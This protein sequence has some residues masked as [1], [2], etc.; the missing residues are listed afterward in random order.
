M[1]VCVYSQ[2]QSLVIDIGLIFM[3]TFLMA[4]SAYVRIPLF[5][6]PV[7]LTLQ[8]LVLF[9]SI[10]FLKNKSVFSQVL[11]ILCGV[12]GLPIFTNAGGGLAYLLGPTGGY[13]IGF[14]IV[15][16]IFPHFLRANKSWV[17]NFVFFLLAG[18]VYFSIGAMW[19]V[20][21]HHFS[22]QTAFSAGV[23]PFVV[24]DTL[25]ALVAAGICS[26]IQS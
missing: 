6:T 13:L 16:L 20:W 14:F 26:R 11:Y 17:S 3:F 5:F 12:A 1:R 24:G 21:L 9:L 15:A 4:A 7:P 19:L 25:K 10:I 8:T 23:L 18:V 2:K 22:P